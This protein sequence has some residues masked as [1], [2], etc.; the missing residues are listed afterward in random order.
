LQEFIDTSDI[1][2]E[3]AQLCAKLAELHRKSCSPEGKF[4]FHTK[5]CQGGVPQTIDWDPKWSSFFKRLITDLFYAELIANGPWPAYEMAFDKLIL[6]VLPKLLDPL[7]TNGRSIKP[8]LVHGNLNFGNAPTNL[9]TGAPIFFDAAAMFAHHEYELGMWRCATANFDDKFIW[10]YFEHYPP[11][12]PME[13]W[14][15]RLCLYSLKFNLAY[16]ISCPGSDVIRERYV[17][18]GTRTKCHY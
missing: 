4:G 12:E 15:D 16:M 6:H 17:Y 18:S 2:P 14:E 3:P 10:Q 13:K 5:N 7:E 8:C 11:S 9:A 1:R